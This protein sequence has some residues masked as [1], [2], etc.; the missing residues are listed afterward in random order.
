MNI[1]IGILLIIYGFS[2][3]NTGLKE[4]FKIQL[5]LRFF[6]EQNKFSPGIWR[7]QNIDERIE[8]NLEIKLSENQVENTESEVGKNLGYEPLSNLENEKTLDKISDNTISFVRSF[9]FQHLPNLNNIRA[10]SKRDLGIDFE[11]LKKGNQDIKIVAY[12]SNNTY[13]KQNESL[14]NVAIFSRKILG[15]AENT[16]LININD[17]K[18]KNIRTIPVKDK[19]HSVGVLEVNMDGFEK[20]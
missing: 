10:V 2:V 5:D 17:I 4:N 12:I 11:V 14:E 19:F 3:F 18:V 8:S 13:F 15:E 7:K 16:V 6:D 9:S 20:I 1:L